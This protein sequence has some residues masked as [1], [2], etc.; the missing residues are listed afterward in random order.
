M[1][2]KPNLINSKPCVD[3]TSYVSLATNSSSIVSEAFIHTYMCVHWMVTSVRLP[4]HMDAFCLHKYVDL[5]YTS[6]G[7]RTLF[8]SQKLLTSTLPQALNEIISV[9]HLIVTAYFVEVMWYY[10]HP[11]YICTWLRMN[12]VRW[13]SKTLV[14]VVIRRHDAV[15]NYHYLKGRFS[16]DL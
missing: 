5:E 10:R 13:D 3:S 7:I 8:I 15:P 1:L 9:W 16:C 14:C 4:F 6:V 2:N 12:G 11:I